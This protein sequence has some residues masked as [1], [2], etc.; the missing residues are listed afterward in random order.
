MAEQLIAAADRQQNGCVVGR[1]GDR[2]AL[3]RHHVGGDGLLVAI[4]TPADVDE[5]VSGGVEALARA[6]AGVDEADPTPLASPPQEDDVA[7]VGVD[8]HL[9]RIEAENAQLHHSLLSKRTTFEP[10]WS[11]VGAISRCPTGR[12]PAASASASSEPAVKVAIRTSF[13]SSLSAPSGETVW[14]SR[15]TTISPGLFAASI[16]RLE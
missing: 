6:D 2:L 15:R 3:G 13:G 8:V 4:L 14:R 16:A 9:L 1:R 7:A 11:S 12:R 10:T 5:V